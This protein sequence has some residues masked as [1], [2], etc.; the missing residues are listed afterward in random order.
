[1]NSFHRF[2]IPL[3]AGCCLSGSALA[4]AGA[5]DA[6]A[7]PG[8][9]DAGAPQVAVRMQGASVASYAE[10][11]PFYVAVQADL[12]HPWHAYYRN[13]G[14]VGIPMEAKLQEVPGF[15][16]SG[17]YWSLPMR[18]VSEL[19]VAYAYE[20]KVTMV[21]KVVPQ[22]DAPAQA[23]FKAEVSWQVCRE[24]QCANPEQKEVAV[25]LSKGDGAAAPAWG[26]YEDAVTGLEK[27]AW[28]DESRKPFWTQD[29]AAKTVTLTWYT[30]AGV[31]L[32]PAK[33][34]FFSWDNSVLPTAPQKL[35]EK[36]PG[37]YELSMTMN[38]GSDMLYP[39]A[40]GDESGEEDSDEPVLKPLTSLKG[41]L[42]ADGKGVDLELPAQEGASASAA[43]MPAKQPKETAVKA[44]AAETAAWRYKW[45]PWS[46]D[47]MD[48]AL[49][50][51]RPVY[52]DFTAQWCATCIANKKVA[53]SSE[54][55]DL[56]RKGN[57]LMLR[58]DKTKPNPA[59][60]AEMRSLNRSS[61]P[62][63]VLYMPGKEP[64]ITREI[65]TPDYLA[66][67]LKAHLFGE[68][69]VSAM[70]EEP[71][72]VSSIWV[73]LGSLFLGGLILNLM[74]C[75]FPVIGLK[76]LGFVE[77]GGGDRKKVFAHSMSFSFGV[78]LSFWLLTLVIFYLRAQAGGEAQS[79]GAWLQNPWV[80]Y[81]IILIFLTMGLSMF[82][83]FEI[84]V[85]AT[86]A[87]SSLQS[88]KGYIGSF[89]SGLL[90][91][92]VATPCSAP[93]LGP[94]MASVMAFDAGMM[95]LSMTCMGLGLALPYLLMGAFPALVK[96]LPKPGA[97]ME[98]LKQGMS[99]L[100]LGAAAY[101]IGTYNAFFIDS[102][103]L[104]VV[105]IF[106]VVFAAGLWV[107]GRWCPIYRPKATRLT[108]AIIALA[109][110]GI[111]I[112]GSMPDKRIFGEEESA[113]QSAE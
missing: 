78:L 29:L 97:W 110:V 62:V 8:A 93:F 26:K 51:G 67:F 87:G 112:W 74:P 91:T 79:W 99:F 45:E 66:S 10:G 31:K 60:D 71:E 103:D 61:I 54:V 53:Y 1:M 41:L 98:S 108:G 43:A 21:W 33:V 28:L 19:G 109:L 47:V 69:D 16:V 27:P 65:L 2:F 95:F 68:G 94:V 34:Q 12:P 6:S 105:Y 32:D 111:G 80:I 15:T 17:P 58:A 44:T 48:K 63:N 102:F 22:A 40:S 75:V 5:W 57:V 107:Y 106:F 76:I 18:E 56:M 23:D 88:R 7:M 4:Q 86:G 30:P 13:P 64:A 82:G 36:E 90:A 70:V 72:K 92:V 24:G 46:K 77:M 100:L 52:V 38:D 84:G 55:K 14:T 20:G 85:G 37:M 81:G 96:S 73:I 3:M 35:T 11:K 49:A 89:F 113:V 50:E 101:F 39:L 59:I 42:V 83:L 25:S 104:Q 9:A